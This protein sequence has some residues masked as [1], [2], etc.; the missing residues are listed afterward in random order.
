MKQLLKVSYCNRKNHKGKHDG[1]Y[2]FKYNKLKNGNSMNLKVHIFDF[3]SLLNK[4]DSGRK[5]EK[6]FF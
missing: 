5:L 3:V 2:K 1:S 4:M 6:Y